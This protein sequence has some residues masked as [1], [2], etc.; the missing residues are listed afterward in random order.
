[1]PENG[2]VVI[3]IGNGKL[4]LEFWLQII[5]VFLWGSSNEVGIPNVG[6]PKDRHASVCAISVLEFRIDLY[7]DVSDSGSSTMSR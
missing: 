2:I 1:M 4:V 3:R 7:S 6:P 5:G